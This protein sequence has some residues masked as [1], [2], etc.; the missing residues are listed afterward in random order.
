MNF[1]G[2]QCL[3][4][5][6]LVPFSHR[7]PTTFLCVSRVLLLC[8]ALLPSTAS[9]AEDTGSRTH[10][11][12]IPS[13]RLGKTCDVHK[14]LQYTCLASADISSPEWHR[15]RQAGPTYMHTT[16]DRSRRR[17]E[18][19]HVCMGIIPHPGLLEGALLVLLVCP[20][21]GLAVAVAGLASGL[22]GLPRALRRLRVHAPLLVLPEQRAVHL[23]TQKRSII[24]DINGRCVQWYLLKGLTSMCEAAFGKRCLSSSR[25]GYSL[26]VSRRN[27]HPSKHS[28]KHKV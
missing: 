21:V 3:I 25:L 26:L 28:H 10:L 9:R 16:Q 1:H 19:L 6:M 18:P 23:A 7:L 20:F 14:Y 27:C 17:Q 5:V 11:L 22:G 2:E 8:S 4:C 15:S 13:A 24:Q 12:S